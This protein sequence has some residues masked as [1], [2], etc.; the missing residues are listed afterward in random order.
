MKYAYLIFIFIVNAFT[1]QGTGV[2]STMQISKEQWQEITEGR[3]YTENFQSREEKKETHSPSAPGN[4]NLNI[5]G[6]KYVLYV[7]V[8]AL[9]VYLCVRV[10]KNFS[11]N[12]EVKQKTVTLDAMKEIEEN[13]HEINLEDLLQ[14][15]LR[16]KNYRIALR[17]HFL[18]IIKLLSQKGEINWAKEKTNWEYYSELRNRDFAAPFKEI[19]LSFENF[20][21]GEHPF[22]E[23]DYHTSEGVYRSLQKKLS[24][25][26]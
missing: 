23:L 25:H 22:T 12:A 13:I 14:E 10:F 18:I 9:V 8:L 21:Y 20:W 3:D 2:D 17:L 24:S 6:F 1:A 11:N 7:L 19:I 4:F 16:S 15:A 26:E 5:P